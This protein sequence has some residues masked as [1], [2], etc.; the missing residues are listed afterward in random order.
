MLVVQARQGPQRERVEHVDQDVLD[1]LLV[2]LGDRRGVVAETAVALDQP[3]VPGA[4]VAQPAVH[5]VVFG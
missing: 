5:A 2:A 3:E 4:V 1:V